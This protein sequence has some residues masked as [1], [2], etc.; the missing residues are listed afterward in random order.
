M[1]FHITKREVWVDAQ[2][3]GIYAHESL[4]LEGFIHCSR[5]NQLIKV[6]NHHYKGESG[7]VL[8]CIDPAKVSAPVVDEDLYGLN[9]TFPHIYGKLNIDAVTG[10]IAF[11]PAEDGLFL[12]PDQLKINRESS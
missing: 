10:V 3:E 2:K 12:L 8:L 5:V 6:A 9:E 1:I 4:G 11:E 7:L